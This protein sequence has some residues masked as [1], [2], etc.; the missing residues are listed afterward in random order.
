[1]KFIFLTDSH[2]TDKMNSRTDNYAETILAKW[3][4]IR[5]YARKNNINTIIH[6]GD[7]FDRSIVPRSL[8]QRVFKFYA[9]FSYSF[10]HIAQYIIAGQHD[11]SQGSTTLGGKSAWYLFNLQYNTFDVRIDA[12]GLAEINDNGE[13]ITMCT[14]YA[15]INSVATDV[16]I[17]HQM[18]NDGALPFEH[19]DINTLDITPRICLSGDYHSGFPVK[20]VNNTYFGNPGA[21]SRTFRSKDDL[22]REPQ[23]AVIDTDLLPACP[24]TYIPISQVYADYKSAAE[25]CVKFTEPALLDITAKER[26]NKLQESVSSAVDQAKLYRISNWEDRLKAVEDDAEL[27]AILSADGLDVQAGCARLRELCEEREMD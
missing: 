12:T 23:F 22:S 11:Y 9:D 19:I 5:T 27:L 3:D 10:P 1:M 26:R 8:E 16:A 7:I 20:K 14:P 2:I 18:L 13:S 25:V 24:I 21:L 15:D 4:A 6:G 17:V